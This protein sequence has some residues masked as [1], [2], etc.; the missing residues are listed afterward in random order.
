ML[1]GML[2]LPKNSPPHLFSV[3]EV[4]SCNIT[5]VINFY[6]FFQIV[7]VKTECIISLTSYIENKNS[8]PDYSLLAIYS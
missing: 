2:A 5:A 7:K 6:F 1:V 8:M 3:H 4:G